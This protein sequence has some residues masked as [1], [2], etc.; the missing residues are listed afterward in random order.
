MFRTFDFTFL[1]R[2]WIIDIVIEEIPEKCISI[3]CSA[4]YS[5]QTH[6]LVKLSG[7]SICIHAMSLDQ[8]YVVAKSVATVCR[9]GGD[10]AEAQAH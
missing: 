7:G 10:L 5:I 3:L 9:D 1:W 2:P 8:W 6:S 4:V